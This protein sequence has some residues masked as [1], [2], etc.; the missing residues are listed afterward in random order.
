MEVEQQM[1]Q[2]MTTRANI[3]GLLQLKALHKSFHSQNRYFL[4]SDLSFARDSTGLECKVRDLKSWPL[5]YFASKQPEGQFNIFRC[6]HPGSLF[7]PKTNV[8][9]R[10][11]H[12]S[13]PYAHGN[14]QFDV[15]LRCNSIR[16]FPGKVQNYSLLF[17]GVRIGHVRRYYRHHS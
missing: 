7:Q 12:R 16:L 5:I 15:H 4:S 14:E 11:H 1:K 13:F 17:V 2:S 9:Q 3:K 8:R 10:H 6:S